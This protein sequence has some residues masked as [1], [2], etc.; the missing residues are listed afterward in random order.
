MPRFPDLTQV[1]D[2]VQSLPQGTRVV[3]GGG[4]RVDYMAEK[5]AG[6]RGL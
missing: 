3:T 4:G 1:I 6:W 2:Y 5:A